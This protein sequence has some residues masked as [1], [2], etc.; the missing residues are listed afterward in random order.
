MNKTANRNQIDDKLFVL[1]KTC[2]EYKEDNKFANWILYAV[3]R[4]IFTERA[5]IE[6][7]YKFVN[8]P[9]EKML[10]LIKYCLKRDM[11]DD[12]IIKSVNKV[13]SKKKN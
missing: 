1:Q 7:E 10:E 6:F 11:S 8:Y 9:N 4:Y 3:R 13:I 2:M 12:G 5:S